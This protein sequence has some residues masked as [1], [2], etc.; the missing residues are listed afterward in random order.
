MLCHP[1][2]RNRYRTSVCNVVEDIGHCVGG[3]Q[4]GVTALTC[5]LMCHVSTRWMMM[6]W[7]AEVCSDHL[8]SGRHLCAIGEV[9]WHAFVQMMFS[10]FVR[11][12]IVIGLPHVVTAEAC[13]RVRVAECYWHC[14]VCI[15]PY[16]DD[17]LRCVVVICCPVW[18]HL[19]ALHQFGVP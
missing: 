15:V 1:F 19:R 9:T 7:Q 17:I 2:N 4:R 16:V 10:N 3:M 8:P 11:C 14:W 12:M 18:L 6:T 5:V 13:K